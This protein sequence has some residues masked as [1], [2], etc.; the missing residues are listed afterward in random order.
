MQTIQTKFQ[1][2]VSQQ[3]KKNNNNNKKNKKKN[4]KQK[5]ILHS[6]LT[7]GIGTVQGVFTGEQR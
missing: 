4:K 1:A 2:L 3:I 5:T 7:V 6:A